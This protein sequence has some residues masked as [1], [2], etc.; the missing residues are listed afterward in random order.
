[1][2]LAP[3]GRGRTVLLQ[4]RVGNRRPNV[5]FRSRN[6][7]RRVRRGEDR[8]QILCAAA[9]KETP[10]R[11]RNLAMCVPRER[12]RGWPA[13]RRC[14]RAA[15]VFRVLT[16]PRAALCRQVSASAQDP[17]NAACGDGSGAFFSDSTFSSDGRLVRAHVASH[18]GAAACSPAR[19]LRRSTDRLSPCLALQTDSRA[20][21]APLTRRK[22]EQTCFCCATKCALRRA[23]AH[24]GCSA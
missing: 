3:R 17:A 9:S 13:Y 15:E 12:G 24:C 23:R 21:L 1:M 2:S 18:D 8:Q 7:T 22:C 10:C 19:A 14:T 16:Q 5:P 11:S 6:A 4:T 20:P